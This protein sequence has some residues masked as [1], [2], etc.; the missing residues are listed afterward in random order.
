MENAANALKIS[1]SILMALIVISFL[2]YFYNSLS[3]LQQERQ[4]QEEIRQ[5]VEYNKIYES[6]NKSTL[7]GSELISL[8]NKVIDNN[9]KLETYG[10]DKY[11]EIVM[12]IKITKEY[13]SDITSFTGVTGQKINPGTYTIKKGSYGFMENYEK[14]MNDIYTIST[15]TV[16]TADGSRT[17]SFQQISM[18]S[19]RLKENFWAACNT[20]SS[21]L[22]EKYEKFEQLV[23]DQK[24]FSRAAFARDG[25]FA[26]NP[27]NA[28]INLIKYKEE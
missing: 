1:A 17:F 21:D 11:S 28:R 6:F 13:F 9:I 23:G 7:M 27:N 5:S 19:T 18:M 16:T 26:Y 2:V 3:E 14:V 12:K 20:S 22:D 4:N 15:N 24:D 8:T 25:S 10:D